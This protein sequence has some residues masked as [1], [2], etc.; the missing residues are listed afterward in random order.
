MTRAEILKW[1]DVLQTVPFGGL[2]I[3]ENG[4]EERCDIHELLNEITDFMFTE[5]VSKEVYDA[6]HNARKDA[7]FKLYKLTHA[8]P[9]NDVISRQA[10]LELIENSYYDLAYCSETIALQEDIKSLPPVTPTR[11]KGEDDRPKGEWKDCGEIEPW[12]RCSECKEKVWGAHK[13]FCPNCGADMRGE[14]NG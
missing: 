6:E 3:K 2:Y 10:V 13:N 4:K 5:K 8:E 14:E 1:I 12:Y 11:P 9:C 7:E